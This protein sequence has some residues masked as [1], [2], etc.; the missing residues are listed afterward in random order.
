MCFVPDRRPEFHCAVPCF[1]NAPSKQ[2]EREGEES[3]RG[4][5]REGGRGRERERE[6]ERERTN[7]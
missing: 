1:R 4:S 6:R 3:E 5:K 2:G 7:G